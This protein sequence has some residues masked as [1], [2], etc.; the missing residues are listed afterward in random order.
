MGTPSS[1]RR[2]LCTADVAAPMSYL[3][4]EKRCLREPNWGD[5]GMVGSDLEGGVQLVHPRLF[6]GLVW[7]NRPWLCFFGINI[8]GCRDLN[9]H[10]ATISHCIPPFSLSLSSSPMLLFSP[11]SSVPPILIFS[12]GLQQRMDNLPLHPPACRVSHLPQAQ[13]RMGGTATQSLLPSLKFT[14]APSSRL[15]R[16]FCLLVSV[17]LL[18]LLDLLDIFKVIHNNFFYLLLLQLLFLPLDSFSQH[19]TLC[20]ANHCTPTGPP[21]APQ[22]RG[23]AGSAMGCY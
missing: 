9:V 23:V 1:R 10:R 16:F 6:L 5:G 8:W 13:Q 3:S 11:S 12:R 21:N 17:F 7:L 19:C 14:L 4:L 15:I 18:R 20:R 2:V 22:R